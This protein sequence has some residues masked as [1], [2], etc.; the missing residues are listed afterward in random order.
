MRAAVFSDDGRIAVLDRALRELRPGEARLAVTSVGI[1]GSDLNL[2]HDNGAMASGVQPGHE[3]AGIVDAVGDGVALATGT[4]VALEPVAGCGDCPQCRRG[5]HNLC[6]AVRLF[7][8]SRP[9]GMAEYL[10]VPATLLHAVDTSLSADVT[11]LA[12]PMAVVVRGMRLAAIGMNERVAVLGSGTIGLLGVVAARAAGAGEVLATARYP[13][14]GELA[15]ALGADAVFASST[16]LLDAVGNQHVDLVVETVGGHADTLTEAVEVA[17]NGG[18]IL[19]LGVFDGRPR[20]P[21]FEFFQKE[22]TL[23][24]SNCYGRECHQSDFAIATRLDERHRRE[25][26]PLITHR[27]KLDQV[28]EAFAT[29]ADKRS[30]SVKVQVQP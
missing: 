6:P 20:L 23:K 11:A 8:F 13:H 26:E 21:A 14:Q 5:A 9:G 7:G 24:A 15:R 19:M 12:E 1:C 4:P 3:V 28:A 22:L 27:F 2:L 17:R 10:N 18:R 25:I 16:E 29:A 30:N